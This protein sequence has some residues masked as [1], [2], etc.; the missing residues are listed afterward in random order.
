MDTIGARIQRL[1]HS[2]RRPAY[3]PSLARRAASLSHYRPCSGN[4]QIATA[5]APT[6]HRGHAR[7]TGTHCPSTSLS[8]DWGQAWRS[9]GH[10]WDLARPIAKTANA[11]YLNIGISGTGVSFALQRNSNRPLEYDSSRISDGPN[12]PLS[13]NKCRGGPTRRFARR[14]PP[15]SFRGRA[16]CHSICQPAGSSRLMFMRPMRPLEAR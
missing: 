3:D 11:T 14:D 12:L 7:K 8:V 5:I 4:A 9:D 16:P 6:L 15:L 13:R 2:V 10:I 1:V